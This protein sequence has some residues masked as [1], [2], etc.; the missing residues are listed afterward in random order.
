MDYAD[1]LI[2]QAA[3]TIWDECDECGREMTQ[4]ESPLIEEA[5]ADRFYDR[6]AVEVAEPS[7]DLIGDLTD[8]PSVLSA[9]DPY[10]G[11]RWPAFLRKSGIAMS[12]DR[13]RVI[14]NQ[15]RRALIIRSFGIPSLVQRLSVAKTEIERA[16]VWW[17]ES[18]AC[19]AG[20]TIPDLSSENLYL[21][22]P[23]ITVPALKFADPRVERLAASK[24]ESE[25]NPEPIR[26]RGRPGKSAQEKRE[27][28]AARQRRYRAK[29]RPSVVGKIDNV[30]RGVFS[31]DGIFPTTATIENKA[32]A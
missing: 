3:A 29:R 13:K 9:L 22:N 6:P 12:T 17:R 25:P 24:V 32:V 2:E 11:S 1:T 8:C 5:N 28:K 23:F 31:E 18:V 21:L 20:D 14:D 7:A 27:T 19:S 4:D 10:A 26:R 15:S 16:R 30:P